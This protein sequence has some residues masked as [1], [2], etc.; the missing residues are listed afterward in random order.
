[1]SAF[2]KLESKCNNN[3]FCLFALIDPDTKYDNKI[4]YNESKIMGSYLESI[5]KLPDLIIS[6]T[7]LRAVMT[8][9]LAMESAD[10][11]S[12]LLLEKGIYGGSP[13]FLLK[14]LQEQ[15][16]KYKSICLVGH[17]PNFSRFIME[18]INDN[19]IYFPTAAIAKIDFQFKNWN[20][21]DWNLSTY[22]F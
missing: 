14:L 20:D 22:N 18:S 15:D 12:P 11:T 13:E 4:G 8:I 3:G 7:A 21:L 1:M 2:S 9:K 17:E 19:Y 16:N 6:S 10:C 5:N